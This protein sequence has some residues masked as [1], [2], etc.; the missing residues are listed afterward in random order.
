MTAAAGA[1]GLAEVA[2][3][4]SQ[5]TKFPQAA[6]A[7]KNA[8]VATGGG[9]AKGAK[10]IGSA[11][12]AGA[13]AVKQKVTGHRRDLEEDNEENEEEVEAAALLSRSPQPEMEADVNNLY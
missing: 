9:I 7:V 12:A 13:K 6:K 3:T 1:F 2:V 8:I 10:C 11:C 5:G 4:G